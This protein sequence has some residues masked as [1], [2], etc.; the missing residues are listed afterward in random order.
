M[1]ECAGKQLGAKH[2]AHLV[3]ELVLGLCNALACSVALKSIELFENENYMGKIKNIE[4]ITRRELAGL[5][6]P[7]IREVRIMGGCACI[8]VRDPET[9]E[10][11][12]EFAL[13]RGVFLRPFLNYMYTMVPYVVAEPEL[14]R[15]FGVMREW[16]EHR[17]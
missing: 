13:D 3:V 1:A 15:V 9:L 16:F 17:G 7:L 4:S 12:K 11:F 14:V 6:D 2:I 10:G 5:S 8:E